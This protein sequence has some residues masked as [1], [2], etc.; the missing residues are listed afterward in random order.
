MLTS[1]NNA[2]NQ[3]IRPD[4]LSPL[5]TTVGSKRV[6]Y[7]TQLNYSLI[8]ISLNCFLN[9]I[10]TGKMTE[11]LFFFELIRARKKCTKSKIKKNQVANTFFASRTHKKGNEFK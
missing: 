2:S 10:T 5:P 9:V 7:F 4:Y 1:A 8:K 11:F 6:L 3:Y